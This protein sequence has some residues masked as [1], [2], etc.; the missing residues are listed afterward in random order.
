MTDAR[1]L[2]TTAHRVVVKIGTRVVT[3]A[4]PGLD[5]EFLDGLARQVA[6]LQE[7][8][9]EIVVVTSGAV[10]LGRR[11]LGLKARG[12][13]IS[14]R[15]AAAAV[16]Q[17]ELMRNYME[18]FAAHRLLTAQLLLTRDDV[19]DRH[20]YVH[21]SNT[22]I[23]L[24]RHHVVPI[25]NENDS[26]SVEGVTFVE[27]DLLAALVAA[28]TRADALVF[29]SD[30]DGLFDCNPNTNA[31]ARLIPVVQPE[32]D[33]SR[34]AEGAGGPESR[35]GM[36]KKCEAAR[37]AS[38]AGIP[39]IMANGHEPNVLLRIL[40]GEPLGTLFI[41]GDALP[42]RKR[43]IASVARAAGEMV[44]DE[45]ACKALSKPGGSSLLPA[46]IVAVHGAFQAGDVVRVVDTEGREVG[47]GLVNYSFSEVDTIRGHHTRDIVGLLGHVGHAEVVHRDN[48]VLSGD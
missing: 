11:A 19:E 43:W 39:S 18:A 17:P 28:K 26:V 32:D 44:V 23:N 9:R 41:G 47:R 31:C 30:Q 36:E 10:H 13:D 37:L 15:Q 16:G 4:G 42:A 14:L 22:L 2:L 48:M 45:G 25:I 1:A 21:L 6:R 7:R 24:L 5:G 34:F 27:N 40:E 33:V 35:G 3:S 29:L 8:D 38:N 12:E 46:G 20:R